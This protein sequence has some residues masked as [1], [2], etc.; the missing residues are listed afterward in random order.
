MNLCY[1]DVENLNFGIDECDE[2]NS[3]EDKENPTPTSNPQFVPSCNSDHVGKKLE[4]RVGKH[5]FLVWN[6]FTIINKEN[7]KGDV[8]NVAQCKYCKKYI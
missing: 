3:F 6:H 5:T 7:S 1:L 8:E 4:V 2:F